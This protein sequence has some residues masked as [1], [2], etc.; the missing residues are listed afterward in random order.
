[1]WIEQAAAA[2][3]AGLKGLVQEL[4]ESLRAEGLRFAEAKAAVRYECVSEHGWLRLPYLCT[5][6][7]CGSYPDV[8]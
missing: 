3:A 4:S 1:M 6:F 5:D 7:S 2:E 8:D